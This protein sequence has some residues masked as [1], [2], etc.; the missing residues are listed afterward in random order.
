MKTVLDEPL[1]FHCSSLE[2]RPHDR[3]TAR[4]APAGRD[5]VMLELSP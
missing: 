2:S 5:A 3:G 1:P 4:T